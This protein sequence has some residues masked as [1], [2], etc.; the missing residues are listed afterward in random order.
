M[1]KFC[2]FGIPVL[3]VFYL[4]CLLDRLRKLDP[5]LADTFGA[6]K[7]VLYGTKSDPERAAL[8]LIRQMFDHFFGLLAPDDLVRKSPYWEKKKGNNPD[9]VS[10]M[11][12]LKY[13]AYEH[14][15]DDTKRERLLATAKHML[16]VYNA[17]NRAHTRGKLDVSKAR[18]AL[19]EMESLIQNWVIAIEL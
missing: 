5:A 17:L 4:I 12:R 18:S 11:E 14:V 6:I 8:Y 13:A 2:R 16:Y 3:Y 1:K 7:E 15:S 9:L 10:R 19:R